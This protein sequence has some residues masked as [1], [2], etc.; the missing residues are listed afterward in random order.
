MKV[1]K[2][3]VKSVVKKAVVLIAASLA[4]I[5]LFACGGKVETKTEYP[6]INIDQ[7]A[8]LSNGNKINSKEVVTDG[9]FNGGNVASSV[10][11]DDMVDYV[12]QYAD[13]LKDEVN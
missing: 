5:S 10:K 8:N 9:N 1:N 12:P 6:S 13:L 3:K 7:D 2:E 4:T 11:A